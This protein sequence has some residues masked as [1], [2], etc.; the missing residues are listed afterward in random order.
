MNKGFST[1]ILI[2]GIAAAII[3]GGFLTYQYW[4]L[5]KEEAKAPEELTEDETANWQ[6]YRNEEYGFE[7]KY[8]S[9]WSLEAKNET[10][11]LSI[12]IEDLKNLPTEPPGIGLYQGYVDDIREKIKNKAIKGYIE[13]NGGKGFVEMRCT[14]EGNPPSPFYKLNF[15]S[16][17]KWFYIGVIDFK[18]VW[19]WTPEGRD[20]C[21]DYLERIFLTEKTNDPEYKTYDE[22]ITLIQSTL[23]IENETLDETADWQI[24]RNKELGYEIK[25]PKDF[26]LI[27][28]E[29]RTLISSEPSP[30]PYA[31]Y[32]PTE[33]ATID[34]YRYPNYKNRSIDQFVFSGNGEKII[35]N[36]EE[37]CRKIDPEFP[38]VFT[39][40]V[41]GDSYTYVL[42][43]ASA[44]KEYF[45]Q[46]QKL[47][48]KIENTFK[49]IEKEELLVPTGVETSKNSGW[50]IYKNTKYKYAIE[51]PDEIDIEDSEHI[52]S[53]RLSE[54][55]RRINFYL[56]KH[57]AIPN[58]AIE[59]SMTYD[60]EKKSLSREEFINQFISINPKY[61]S[62]DATNIFKQM[63]STF[64]FLD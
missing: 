23:K 42:R 6:T 30:S 24:Y 53:G 29:E 32:N 61:D 59:V 27:P 11:Y 17:D 10:P 16:D 62:I 50:W 9:S 14:Y 46:Y 36:G 64:K 19:S 54:S 38:G 43:G 31:E 39:Y 37:A 21:Y 3:A 18:R 35:I 33:R 49:F 7:F 12:S 45:S 44:K 56:E 40:F 51:F 63:L 41:R 34:I 28:Y 25:Y 47:I 60:P 22:F 1:I 5:P 8:P 55:S 57:P 20:A 2:V 26:Y 15:L 48:E 13:F 52:L 4:W 58:L